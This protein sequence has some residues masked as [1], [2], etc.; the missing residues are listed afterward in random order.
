V[1]PEKTEDDAEGL[2]H[3]AGAEAAA[4]AAVRVWTAETNPAAFARIQHDLA[5]TL[6]S[7]AL[8]LPETES[9]AAFEAARAAFDAALSV[10]TE[11]AAPEPRARALGNRALLALQGADR[12]AAGDAKAA[13]AAA[14]ADLE[15]A[16]PLFER[17]G[18]AAEAAF[19]E[20]ELAG[21]RA[22]QADG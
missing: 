13:L 9:G 22:R 2:A 4:R 18:L 11:A 5:F 10:W 15:A 20:E 16:L 14:K 1:L 21:I 7:R 19:A 6:A 17:L 12:P 3:L 8:T